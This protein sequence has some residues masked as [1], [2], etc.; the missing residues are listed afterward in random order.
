[1]KSVA[2]KAPLLPAWLRSS[3]MI[4]A[5]SVIIGIAIWQLG[6]E[7]LARTYYFKAYAINHFFASPWQVIQTFG[8]LYRS[9]ELLRHCYFS[10]LEFVYG[11]SLA[12]VVGIPIGFLMAVH[13][14]INYYLDPWVSCIYATPTVALAPIIMVW[15]GLGIF[16]NS[17][18][19]FLGAVFPILLNTYTGIKS[20]REN[21]INVVR[22]FGGSPL[23]V[24]FKVMIPD[25]TP[26]IIVGLRLAVGRAVIS[27]AVAELFG[28][29]AGL[30]FMVYFYSQRFLPGPVFVG[31]V[32]LVVFGILSFLALEKI[33]SWLSPWYTYQLQRQV[34]RMEVE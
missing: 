18:V 5:C 2:K 4:A 32:V 17:L 29:E 15:F 7:G 31:I 11:F 23:Q 28:S 14:K 27:V 22:A 33:Q 12:I 24:F 3:R 34:Y 10:F 8:E 16:P 21:L 20:V 25:A 9:G 26:A 13:K 19:V 6:Y 1:M 30:G